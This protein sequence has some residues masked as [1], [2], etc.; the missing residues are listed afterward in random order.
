M[1]AI[2]W[3]VVMPMLARAR[4]RKRL[5]SCQQNLK[6]ISLAFQMYAKEWDGMYPPKKRVAGSGDP[7]GDRYVLAPEGRSIYPDYLSDL[8]ILICP[9]DVQISRLHNEW[10]SSL[11]GRGDPNAI[12]DFIDQSSYIYTGYAAYTG[13]NGKVT[14]EAASQF[15]QF[16]CAVL[17][18]VWTDFDSDMRFSEEQ[19]EECKEYTIDHSGVIY[20][21]REG[22][23]KLLV[24]DATDTA[25]VATAESE[26][27]V[28][29]DALAALSFGLPPSEYPQVLRFN[30]VPGGCNVM[31][32]D[33]HVE[34][35]RY[36][37][38]FPVTWPVAHGLEKIM[39]ESVLNPA[40]W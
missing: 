34:F 11:S 1:I 14:T 36:P 26:I 31:F 10:T 7:R 30:H 28:M 38:E 32:L 13:D 25:S 15:E 22:I 39:P 6:Q 16:L 29:W 19:L 4:E 17:D 40:R 20:R 23:G 33:G 12:R 8:T 9:S 18:L 3:A 21:L 37:G 24:T 5:I 35:V 27:A 2:L